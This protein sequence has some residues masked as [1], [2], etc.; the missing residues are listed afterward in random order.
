MRA[1]CGEISISFGQTAAHKIVREIN[2]L[3]RA[4]RPVPIK[5]MRFRLI[6]LAVGGIKDVWRL[7]AA[8]VL[9]SI[10]MARKTTA[11]PATKP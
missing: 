4:S 5:I 9:L 10:K 3:A 1:T 7:A 6:S 11:K 2:T 8:L